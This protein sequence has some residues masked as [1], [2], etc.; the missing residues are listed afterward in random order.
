MIQQ[1]TAC[2]VCGSSKLYPFFDLGEQPFANALLKDPN[3]KD[4]VYPLA[5]TYCEKCSLVQLTHRADQE[6]LFSQYV[7]VTGTSKKIHEFAEVFCDRL[8]NRTKNPQSGYVLEIASNDGTLLK[9]F[10][11]RGFTVLGIDPAQNIAE[12]ANKSGIPTEPYFWGIESAKKVV[13]DHGKARVLFARN[14]LPHVS[15]Q[16]DFVEGLAYAL[17]ENGTLAIEVHYAGVI[18]EELHYDSIYHEHHCY[19]SLKN[20]E[21]LLNSHGLYIFDIE[22]SPV[23]GGSIIVYCKKE[24]GAESDALVQY[25]S[26]EGVTGVNT[27]SAWKSFA[28]RSFAHKDAFL[29]LFSQLQSGHKKVVGYGASARSST[30]LNF[31]GVTKEMLPCIADKA[32]L[33]QGLYTAGTHIP[34]VSIDNM[35]KETPH[36]ICILAWNFKDEIIEELRERD[37]KGTFLVPFPDSPHLI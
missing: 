11:N 9:P 22:E 29:A 3:A 34:I 32:P 13:R 16:R 37:F 7:W 25:R 10:K 30:L 20:L 2:R 28:T 6:E 23:S 27:L 19:F 21:Q 24:K 15:D 33:K 18:L 4:P 17:E 31:C 35:L 36:V 26:N 14:V 1:V 12:I 8:T 5:L